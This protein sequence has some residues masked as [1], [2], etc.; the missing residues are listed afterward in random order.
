MGWK[1]GVKRKLL[2][3]SARG[4]MKRV[5]PRTDEK[6]DIAGRP[7]VVRI[8][9]VR[10][11]PEVAVIAVEVEQVKIAIGVGF[12]QSAIQSTTL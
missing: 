9:I 5:A 12:A 4:E 6:P 7:Q 8:V 1:A 3:E 11:E 10:V 2:C